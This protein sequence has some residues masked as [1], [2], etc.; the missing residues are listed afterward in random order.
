MIA[1]AAGNLDAA[2]TLLDAG[3]DP[4]Q[5]DDDGNTALFYAVDSDSQAVVDLLLHHGARLQAHNNSG[6]NIYQYAKNHFNARSGQRYP[7]D[8]LH[9]FRTEYGFDEAGETPH[10]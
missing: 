10:N 1:C 7:Y 2:S 5:V 8:L 3:A 6:K 4:N 9:V